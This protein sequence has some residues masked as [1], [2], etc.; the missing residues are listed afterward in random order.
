MCVELPLITSG[1]SRLSREKT[2]HEM[3]HPL[4]VEGKN[5]FSISRTTELEDEA[6]SL[7]LHHWA[8]L[9]LERCLII[10]RCFILQSDSVSLFRTSAKELF[11]RTLLR[12]VFIKLSTRF[13]SSLYLRDALAEG[14]ASNYRKVGRKTLRQWVKVTKELKLLRSQHGNSC[15]VGIHQWSLL[16]KHFFFS[17]IRQVLLVRGSSWPIDETKNRLNATIEWNE[18]NSLMRGL[19][20]L[21]RHI[22]NTAQYRNKM[23]ITS[24]FEREV[25]LS[26]HLKM[27]KS[28]TG[29]R[30]QLTQHLS[31]KVLFLH[32]KKIA[33]RSWL[34]VVFARKW[35]LHK[36][37][38]LLR[39]S[40]Y[41]WKCQTAKSSARLSSIRG[42]AE[43]LTTGN[44]RDRLRKYISV[45]NIKEHE[46]LHSSGISVRISD[47]AVGIAAISRLSHLAY[48]EKLRLA[49]CIAL[50]RALRL[51]EKNRRM[52]STVR[53]AEKKTLTYASDAYNVRRLKQWQVK[54]SDMRSLKTR[55]D[56]FKMLR[57]RQRAVR[58][59]QLWA[60]ECKR[61]VHWCVME[62]RAASMADRS[63]G[64][65][66]FEGWCSVIV[67]M[68]LK[69]LR[70]AKATALGNLCLERRI[71]VLFIQGVG[72]Q[73]RQRSQTAL[74]L[75]WWKNAMQRT[76]W[77]AF[78]QHLKV[79]RFKRKQTK[80][81][82]DIWHMMLLRDGAAQWALAANKAREHR[83]SFSIRKEKEKASR[84]WVLVERCAQQWKKTV[85]RRKAQK[86]APTR[87]T[88]M[89]IGDDET[90]FTGIHIKRSPPPS[91]SVPLWGCNAELSSA[92][93]PLLPQR[94]AALARSIT[95]VTPTDTVIGFSK[96][97]HRPPPRRP[98]ELLFD[99]LDS[100]SV[101]SARPWVIDVR[102]CLLEHTHELVASH[103]DTRRNL[104][105]AILML[106]AKIHHQHLINPLLYKI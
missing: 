38:H 100:S 33:F 20:M 89:L 26:R 90:S 58:M 18:K 9:R 30:T 103:S 69:R 52:I 32:R 35:L 36:W 75:H 11:R 6:T 2:S 59:I 80:R 96:M 99:T 81:A 14:E 74:A 67:N 82:A 102:L 95:P 101:S 7:A 22:R 13:A 41:C 70:C 105:G 71:F 83:L 68:R 8:T 56:F 50:K 4:V 60:E 98:L 40:L 94:K 44:N 77:R 15:I 45:I 86:V 97:S 85:L 84:R 106:V 88:R 3:V 72:L 37:W 34:D 27:W 92:T 53:D 16:R 42:I 10:W 91:L 17:T 49:Q 61:R 25:I 63:C 79:R 62:A 73:Q 57:V 29:V 43:T 46:R 47:M 48:R 5:V 24:A 54:S 104:I 55:V 28:F 65:R 66:A 93:L 31:T 1:S 51:F 64:R 87:S 78:V 12:S 19:N 39:I 76:V 21:M 23:H